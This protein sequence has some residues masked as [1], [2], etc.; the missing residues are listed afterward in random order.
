MSARIDEINQQLEEL[1]RQTRVLI[2]E[3]KVLEGEAFQE[4]VKAR[5][6]VYRIHFEAKP[7]SGGLNYCRFTSNWG[8]FSTRENAAKY[9]DSFCTT[10]D[11]HRGRVTVVAVASETL[12][13]DV[14]SR[15]DNPVYGHN[16]S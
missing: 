15:L 9:T 3:R 10:L 7:I 16:Y 11:H 4:L 8:C 5:P 2:A 13:Y 1:A 6:V 14:L 12:S